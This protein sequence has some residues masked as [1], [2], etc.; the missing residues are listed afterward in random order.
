MAAI[1]QLDNEIQAAHRE[2]YMVDVDR[3]L[4]ERRRLM[5]LLSQ[6]PIA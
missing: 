2:D 4:D 5:T 6:G 1:R 3:L